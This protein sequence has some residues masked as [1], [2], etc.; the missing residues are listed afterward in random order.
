MN[1]IVTDLELSV[2]L[3]SLGIKQESQFIWVKLHPIDD[4]VWFNFAETRDGEWVLEVND[5]HNRP[6]N[7]ELWVAAFTLTELMDILPQGCTVYRRSG[8]RNGNGS[9]YSC[10]K[11]NAYSKTDRNFFGKTGPEACGMQLAYIAKHPN[12]RQYINQ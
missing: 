6:E 2:E 5:D 7:P 4:L 10:V 3:K 8:Y 12:Y 1:N 9:G 11:G